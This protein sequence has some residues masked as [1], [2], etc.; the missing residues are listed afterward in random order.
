MRS[1]DPDE[2]MP[3]TVYRG[4]TGDLLAGE[5][6]GDPLEV[7]GTLDDYMAPVPAWPTVM[8]PSM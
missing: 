6:Y 1:A 4:A 7:I 5:I 8:S 2:P 3:V